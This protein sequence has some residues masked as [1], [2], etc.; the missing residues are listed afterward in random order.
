MRVVHSSNCSV[1]CG[2]GTRLITYMECQV[3]MDSRNEKRFSCGETIKT[4]SEEC[5]NEPCTAK[6]GDWTSWTPCSRSCLKSVNETSARKRVRGCLS[7]DQSLCQ[8]TEEVQMCENIQFCPLKEHCP[9]YTILGLNTD[10]NDPHQL[11]MQANFS[12]VKADVCI[13]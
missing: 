3:F 6:Y 8:A 7:D 12:M 5:H 2:S 9:N 11:R 4:Q 1:N 13:I 10:K